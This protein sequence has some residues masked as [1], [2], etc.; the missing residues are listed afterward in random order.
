M[1]GI[2]DLNQNKTFSTNRLL[3]RSEDSFVAN[4]ANYGGLRTKGWI[5][6]SVE[7]TP[8][9]SIITVVRN[10]VANIEETI[11]SVLNQTYNNVEYIIVD[12]ASTD[13]TLDIIKKYEKYIDLWVSEPDGGVFFGFNKGVDLVTGK[14]V[15]FLNSGDFYYNNTVLADIFSGKKLDN[16]GMYGSMACHINGRRVI[17][18][19]HEDIKE[20]AWQGMRLIH[21]ALF[22]KAEIIKKFKF[23]TRYKVSGDGDFVL[24]CLANGYNFVKINV[25]VFE[26]RAQGFSAAHWLVAR[27]ENWLISRKYFPGWKANLYHLYGLVYFV[28]FRFFK[29]ILSAIGIYNF[30][31]IYYRR[32]LGD[33]ISREKYHHKEIDSVKNL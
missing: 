25:I 27:K 2:I 33:K 9:V 26:T 4:F 8:L 17:V 7:N 3:K 24:K 5:K 29:Q 15:E 16:D 12:G 11:L 14:W 23:D 21:E 31:K 19:A 18:D 13:G 10:D 28:V 30:L 20:K 32:W 1:D 6:E 22:V